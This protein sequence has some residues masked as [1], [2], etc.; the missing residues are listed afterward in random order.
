MLDAEGRDFVAARRIATL[1]TLSERGT[2]RPVPI[3]FVLGEPRGEGAGTPLYTP[4]D[5]KPKRSADVRALARVRDITARPEVT[6]L[7]ERWSEDWSELAWLRARGSADLVEPLAEPGVHRW[8]V[9]ALR[10]KYPQ[11]RAQ[12]LE[13]SPL[14]RI[15]IDDTVAWSATTEPR[16]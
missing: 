1:V 10:S 9:E 11:Y 2:P 3:C 14:I 5:Q 12:H 15:T 8:A 16:D 13:G 4:L 7:F 6:L